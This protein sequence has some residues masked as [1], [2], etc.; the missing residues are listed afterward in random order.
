MS[1]VLGTEFL[2]FESMVNFVFEVVEGLPEPGVDGWRVGHQFREGGP[3]E[4]G[5]DALRIRMEAAFHFCL[6]LSDLL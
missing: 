1:Q 5:L 2:L 4:A 6:L 3:E